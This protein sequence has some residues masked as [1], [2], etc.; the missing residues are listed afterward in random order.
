MSLV[1]IVIVV[2]ALPLPVLMLLTMLGSRR[3]GVRWPLAVGAGL[4][5]PVTWVVWYVLDEVPYQRAP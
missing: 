5:F 2:V 1:A 4:M 3:R